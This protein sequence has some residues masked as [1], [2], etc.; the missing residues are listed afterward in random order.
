MAFVGVAALGRC[1]FSAGVS[2]CGLQGRPLSVGCGAAVVAPAPRVL[3]R[4]S[5]QAQQGRTQQETDWNV[6][7]VLENSVA[8]EAHRYVVVNVGVTSSTGSLIDAYRY[9]GMYVQ[10]RLNENTKPAFLAISCAPNLQGIF[11]FLIKDND[12]TDWVSKLRAGDSVEMSPVRGRGFPISPTLDVRGYPAIPEEEVPRD[13]LLFA[14][15]SGIAPIRACI[16][17]RLNGIKARSRRTVRLYYGAR[18]PS[19][20]AFKDR[21]PMWREDGIDVVPVMSQAELSDEPWDGKVGYVQDALK[22]EGVA[23]PKQTGALLC[24]LQGMTE[25]VRQ[26]LVDAGVPNDRILLNF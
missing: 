6:V 22:Q 10:M 2:L 12:S 8:C 5:A 17:S 20:M 1:A 9:P 16:E 18:Y 4:A 14:T 15:G 26:M 3:V 7:R 23:Y 25:D 24:G 11:E 21:F 19:R 13:L